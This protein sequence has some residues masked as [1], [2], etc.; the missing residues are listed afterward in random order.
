MGRDGSVYD[1]G[2]VRTVLFRAQSNPEGGRRLLDVLQSY[3]L[4]FCLWASALGMYTFPKFQE[5][6]FYFSNFFTTF[7]D[8][9]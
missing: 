1:N 4:T 9:K 7:S 3:W 6:I 8:I 2:D 5:Q